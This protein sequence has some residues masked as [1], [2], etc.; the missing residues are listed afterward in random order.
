MQVTPFFDL[1]FLWQLLTGLNILDRN[2]VVFLKG[3]NLNF[4][5]VRM[6]FHVGLWHIA[7]LCN[8][9]IRKSSL[10]NRYKCLMKIF[11]CAHVHKRVN[12]AV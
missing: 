1:L 5:G 3:L 8:F 9:N 6:H 10:S 7:Q 12:E 11:L 2:A 4:Q